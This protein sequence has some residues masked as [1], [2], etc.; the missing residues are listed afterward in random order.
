MKNKNF[1]LLILLSWIGLY[2]C[3]KDPPPIPP[4]IID[5]SVL[6]PETQTGANTFGCLVDG[7]VWVPRVP[8]YTVTYRDIEA[9]VWEKDGSGSGSI[10]C[11]LVDVNQQIDNWLQITFGPTNFNIGSY[12][13]GDSNVI[14]SA[15]IRQI[16]SNYYESDYG[17]T[18]ENCVKITK[19]D[20]INKIVSGNFNFTLYKDS[21]KLW[22]KVKISDGRFDL[23]YFPQ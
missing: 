19:I 9:T 7:K 15:S 18:S 13:H 6:P 8:L 23:K 12:C 11:N 17:D 4:Q 1:I 5:Y 22:D 2:A 14:A 10:I 3:K 16:S 20:T 21:L